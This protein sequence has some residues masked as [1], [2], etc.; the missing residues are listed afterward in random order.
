M[1]KTTLIIGAGLSGLVAAHVLHK[2]GTAFTLIDSAD[3]VGGRVRSDIIDGFTLDRGFQVLLDSYPSVKQFLDLPALAPRY[4]DSGAL[5]ADKGD[6]FRLLHPLRHPDWLGST[7]LTP[8]FSWADKFALLSLVLGCIANSDAS[9]LGRLQP[10]DETTNAMLQRL[11]V[12]E[13]MIE[14]FIR[15]FFGGVFLDD[16]LE[17]SAGLFRYYLKKFAL[18]RVL[19]PAGGMGEIPSQLA[20][21]LPAESLR[22]NVPIDHLEIVGSRAIAAVA[23]SGERIEA[24]EFVL[25]TDEI[26]TCQLLGQPNIAARPA[27]GV[28]TVY[29][30]SGQSM[31]TGGLLVLPSTNPLRLITHLVQISNVAPEV[32]PPP[33]RLISVTVLHPGALTDTELSARVIEEVGDIFTEVR[34]HLEP[35][36]VVRTPY[37]QFVQHPDVP[38]QIRG[39]T[40][41]E[42]VRL[43]GDQV[44]TASIESAMSAGANAAK[45]LLAG[46]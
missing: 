21:R 8:A 29:L 2:A 36:H 43:A 28:T 45:A 16:S 31:Y 38:S 26:S 18:G 19:I 9:I 30:K 3:A 41:A 22:L 32:A 5:L 6:F 23:S 14:R 1:S 35:L 39:L 44:G 25:A 7:A 46:R 27:L 37:G 20:A 11:G 40:L 15:P 33:W 12:S 4:F 13:Q 42:N 24:D 10:R 34:G 17:T